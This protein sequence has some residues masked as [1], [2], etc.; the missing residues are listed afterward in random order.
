MPA[1]VQKWGNSLGIRI[2][3]K[4]AEELGI[5]NGSQMEIIVKEGQIILKPAKIELTLEELMVQ[6]TREN[7]HEEIDFGKQEGNELL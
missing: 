6:I 1:T 7:Q 3:K 5:V 4:V 2:P